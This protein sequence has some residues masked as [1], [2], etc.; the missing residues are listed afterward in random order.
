MYTKKIKVNFEKIKKFTLIKMLFEILLENF[1]FIEVY[2][3]IAYKY[4]NNQLFCNE[5]F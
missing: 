1:I 5:S 2:K 4:L 3:R